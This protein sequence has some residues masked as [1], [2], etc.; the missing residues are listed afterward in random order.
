MKREMPRPVSRRGGRF[1]H[2]IVDKLFG[3]R[4]D[5]IAFLYDITGALMYFFIGVFSASLILGN[6]VWWLGGG[7]FAI[8][9]Y[10]LRTFLLRNRLMSP[11][12][13]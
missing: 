6:G 4:F 12:Y 2:K 1:A 13:F 11:R 3:T 8:A 5:G 9:L 7:V 10:V